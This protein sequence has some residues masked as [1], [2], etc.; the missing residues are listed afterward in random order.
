MQFE[1]VCTGTRPLLM[2]NARLASPLDPFAKA[3]KSA[4]APRTKTDDD[5]LAMARIEFEGG[6]YWDKEIGP[7]VPGLNLLACVQEG[8]KIKRGGKKVERG[9]TI[10]EFEIPVIYDGPRSVQGLWDAGFVDIRSVKVAQSRVDRCRPI[11]DQWKLVATAIIDPTVIEEREFRDYVALGGQM[12][13]LGDFRK[14]F[15]RFD[16]EITDTTPA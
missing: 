5:R 13:G 2:H 9:V 7:F 12:A 8:A 15:G 3:M 1:I 11:F 6:L 10:V 4:N 16:V 14:Q